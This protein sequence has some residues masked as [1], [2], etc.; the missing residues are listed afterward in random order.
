MITQLR[1]RGARTQT[2]RR[3]R[4]DVP[5]WVKPPRLPMRITKALTITAIVVI[6][7]YPFVYVIATSFATTHG[8]AANGLFPTQFS[9]GA[10]RSILAGGVVTRS[11]LVSVGV[12]VVGTVL[13][14]SFTVMLAYGLTRTRD[15]PGAKLVLYL[16]LFS[17]LFTAG[18]IPS[19]LLVKY[20]GL[21][22]SYW[23]LVLPGMIS[24][25]NLVVIR[26]FFMGL[27][28]EIYDAA[29]IDG[30]NEW[31]ALYRITLP[32][33]KA[34]IAVIALFYAVGYWNNFF[35]ALL[36]LNNTA[37]WPVQLV[38]NQYVLQGSPLSQVQSPN[39]PIPPAQAV[40]M[41]VT[42]L[43]TAPILL[44]YPF[45]Q[46]YFTKGVLTGAIKG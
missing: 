30:A 32:L 36:Y 44:L 1:L 37:K 46:R 7:A 15:V 39:Q 22:N 3:T 18:I 17:M 34:V 24:A 4:R 5:A 11:L 43:A 42:V 12:T 31:Q 21:I 10:Y 26:N 9:L 28:A 38:L 13:S 29:R 19:Y 2:R 14:I 6:M 45:A 33:S 25:F 35:N 8:M 20:L 27:P 40:Q 16:A 23:S 41:A